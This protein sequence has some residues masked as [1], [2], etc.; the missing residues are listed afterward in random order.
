MTL[1]GQGLPVELI[2]EHAGTIA[3]ELF[4]GITGRVHAELRGVGEADRAPA[5]LGRMRA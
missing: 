5:G 2:A 4:C 3:Y 1:W